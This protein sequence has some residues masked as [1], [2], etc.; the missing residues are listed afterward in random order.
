[1]CIVF[2]IY[3]SF[4][5]KKKNYPKIFKKSL[6]LEIIVLSIYTKLLG[7]LYAKYRS[8]LIKDCPENKKFKTPL[9]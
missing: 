5:I 3:Q 7:T 8:I 2:L 9:V 1:M 6:K 4:E